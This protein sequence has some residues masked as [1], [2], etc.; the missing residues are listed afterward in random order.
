MK[1]LSIFLALGIISAIVFVGVKID[2]LSETIALCAM[3]TGT[4]SNPFVIDGIK[5]DI[6]I[7]YMPRVPISWEQ[8]MELRNEK[9]SSLD[10]RITR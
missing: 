1:V 3:N 7:E 10:M 4:S 2:K 5:G 6:S 9:M 8:S